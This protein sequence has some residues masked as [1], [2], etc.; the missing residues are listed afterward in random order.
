MQNATLP[1]AGV[2]PMSTYQPQQPYAYMPPPTNGLAIAGA[3]LSIVGLLT[4]GILSPLGL[5]LSLV[6]LGKPYGKGWAWTGVILGFLGLCGWG[7]TLFVA[8]AA[9]MAALGLSVAAFAFVN[10]EKVELTTD[11]A[12]IAVQV[13]QYRESNNRILP[14][15]L[16]ILTISDSTRLDPWGTPY[17]YVLDD[18]V[19]MGYDLIS[20]GKDKSPG[21]VD[22]VHLS[23]IEKYWEDAFEQFE[24]KV[25][26]IERGDEDASEPPAPGGTEGQDIG[27]DS[28]G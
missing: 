25:Q 22:D 9:I 3:V 27:G 16:E 17:R 28:P 21:T 14:A 11:M 23:R 8:G 15:N 20:D 6:A 19:K 12:M 1:V 2:S 24:V 10:S 18:T 13:E 4:F 7:I 5:V 26:E